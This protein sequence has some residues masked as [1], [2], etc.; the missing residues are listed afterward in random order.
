[1]G[2]SMAEVVSENAIRFIE[3]QKR[4]IRGQHERNLTRRV[5]NET[6]GFVHR[7]RDLKAKA[8]ATP[9]GTDKKPQSATLIVAAKCTDGVMMAADRRMMRG[10]ESSEEKKIYE[11]CKVAIAFAGLTGLKDKFL[12]TVESVLYSTRAANLT[13]AIVG[14]EDTI[15]AIS[16]RYHP[17]FQI[18][19]PGAEIEALAAGLQFLSRGEARLYHV[20]GNG[21]AEEVSFLCIGHGA[22]YATSIAQGLYQKTLDMK[23]MAEIAVFLIGWV[24]N[25]DTAVGG[26]PDVVFVENEKGC[27][28]MNK[29]E[30]HKIHE[31]TQTIAKLLP[32]LLKRAIKDPLLLVPNKAN[33]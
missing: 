21:Y 32:D 18:A 29:P 16:A 11:F 12:E 9:E 28:E 5:T 19:G 10:M 27:S 3:G 2:K 8:I 6:T 17:R 7:L 4:L 15:A 25:V 23:A 30:I 22:T 26:I 24:S 13:E 20:F 31:D 1:M 14:I 33:L